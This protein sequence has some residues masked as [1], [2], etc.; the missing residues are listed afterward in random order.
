MSVSNDDKILATGDQAGMVHLY[1][2]GTKTLMCSI[3]SVGTHLLDIHMED[4]QSVVFAFEDHLSI[5]NKEGKPIRDYEFSPDKHGK[6]VNIRKRENLIFITTR[7]GLFLIYDILADSAAKILTIQEL[8]G[9]ID[10]N[11]VFF[12]AD[13]TR[14]V[15]GAVTGEIL[16]LEVKSGS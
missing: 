9:D 2:L 15:A 1:E 4:S 12:N 3:K 11:T 14:G 6:V 8:P 5:F 10:L 16:A 7:F 13:F